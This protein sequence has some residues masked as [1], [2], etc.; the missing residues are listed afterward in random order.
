LQKKS[1]ISFDKVQIKG[2]MITVKSN[3]EWAFRFYDS[4]L[5]GLKER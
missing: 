2:I 1:Q 3:F 4:Y 5:A